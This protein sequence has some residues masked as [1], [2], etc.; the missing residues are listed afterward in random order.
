M[1][2]PESFTVETP[3]GEF[4]YHHVDDTLASP[5]DS[6]SLRV[7][8][9]VCVQ[10]S[11]TATAVTAQVQ[12]STRDPLSGP[13]W[14]PAG[15]PITGNPSAGLSIKRYMEPTRGWWRIHVTVLTGGNLIVDISGQKA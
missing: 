13:N 6:T 2:A 12:R 1:S 8:G 15:D 14:A 5:G 3:A 4:T 11:G 9:E 7:V 10:L